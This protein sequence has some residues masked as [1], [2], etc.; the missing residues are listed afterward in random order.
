MKTP[1]PRKLKKRVFRSW[2]TSMVSISLV[3]LMLGAL[4]IVLTN[5]GRLSDYVREQ[6]GFTLILHDGI[7]ETE[8][9]QLQKAIES[10]DYVKSVRYI[11]KET[12]AREL[13]AD[14]G[15]DFTEFLGFNPLFASLDVK[16][17]ASYTHSDSLLI[18]EKEFLNHPQVKEVYY[19]KNLLAVINENV[20]KISFFLLVVSALTGF[21]FI[22]LIN[23][24]IRISIY[25]ERFTINTMQ[26]V[27]ATRSFVRKPFLRRG[28][29]LGILGSLIANA[30]L[31]AAVFSFRKELGG[32]IDPT[33]M[34]VFGPVFL[35]VIVLGMTISWISTRAA[36]NKFLKMKFDELFY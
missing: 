34:V 6:V 5:A 36:V 29:S 3:L 11:D 14:L 33:D 8:V 4:L 28:L 2:L 24:T 19:Q 12:A 25:S 7:K 22:S 32:I 21:I 17:F 27:G 23:N 18:V 26:L 20:R 10:T 9:S 30:L 13:T 1:K 35:L 31:F 15:E 16:L